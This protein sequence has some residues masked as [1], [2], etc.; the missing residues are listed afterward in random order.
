MLQI[1]HTM[2]QIW[3]TMLQKSIFWTLL[4]LGLLLQT[5]PA[6]LR[7]WELRPAGLALAPL[8][9]GNLSVMPPSGTEFDGDGLPE[10]LQ[11][12]GGRLTISSGAGAVWQSPPGWTVLQAQITDLNHDG[13]PE[14][15]LLVWRP[16]RPWPVDQWLPHGGRIAD[17]HD[18]EG[19]SCHIILVGWRG[20]AYAELWAGSALAE[21]VKSFEA[22]D[23][24]GDGV[25]ELVTL[26]GSYTDS[27][28]APA[29]ALKVWEWNGF[30]FSVVS[31]IK[32]KFEKMALVRAD[33]GRILVL[34]P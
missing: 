4:V 29:R 27:R 20:G 19:N 3:Q 16:F 11:L 24:R 21:P 2:L 22:A 34:V 30:G 8:P 17:F 33:S 32:G 31:A 18:N 1:W 12:T 14:A 25:Q 28:S 6:P 7:A 15:T 23:L 9:A 26:E 5:S 13:S 10:R